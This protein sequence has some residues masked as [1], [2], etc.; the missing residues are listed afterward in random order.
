[1]DC[2]EQIVLAYQQGFEWH[3]HPLNNQHIYNVA[4]LSQPPVLIML[5]V[6]F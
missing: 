3:F 2:V 5:L 4:I 1:M 6:C